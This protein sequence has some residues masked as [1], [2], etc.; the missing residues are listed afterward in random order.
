MA[1]HVI[2]ID[3]KGEFAGDIPSEL[4]AIHDRIRATAHGEGFGKGN[5]KAAEEAKKQIEDAIKA[6]RLKLEASMPAERAKWQEIE[7]QNKLVKGQLESLVGDHRKT[8]M[9]REESHAQEITKRAD[10]LAKRDTKIRGLVNQQVRALALSNGARDE[11]ISE[12]EVILGHRIGFDEDMEPYV[13]AEDGTP[14]KTAAGNLL[15]ME[16]FVKQ[17]LDN[18]Q[19]HRKPAPGR[20]GDARGGAT[21]RGQMVGGKTANVDALQERIAAGDR[22]AQTINELFEAT[23]TKR[24][25]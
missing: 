1:K 14:A 7:E 24:A 10:A 21:L 22:G 18:H 3:E 8:L 5:Q 16:V 23:R 12:L 9:S 6:E 15:P 19:H 4:A 11:S 17:Y 25:S 2:D 13:K 20:G